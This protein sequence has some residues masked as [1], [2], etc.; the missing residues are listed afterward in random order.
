MKPPH[1][2]GQEG[3]RRSGSADASASERLGVAARPGGEPDV[4]AANVA[5]RA[6]MADLAAW[7]EE[8]ADDRDDDHDDG[9]APRVDDSAPLRSC[10][11]AEELL[12]ALAQVDGAPR[13]ASL[14]PERRGGADLVPPVRRYDAR[15]LAERLLA[16][17]QQHAVLAA[18][19][20]DL[21]AAQ[22]GL[23]SISEDLLARL[24][25]GL[26]APRVGS[27]VASAVGGTERG[28]L[29]L[30]ALQLYVERTKLRRER[31]FVEKVP[32]AQPDPV[33]ARDERLLEVLAVPHA[34]SRPLGE[35]RPRG[36]PRR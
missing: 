9:G 35:R 21:L 34:A 22:A 18:P 31:R 6:P 20:A 24:L 10:R 19:S 33:G 1:E 30:L 12:L 36:R 3:E 2:H 11:E 32:T 4:A 13:R 23:D 8:L 29:A 28:L 16:E 25:S 5:C 26:S 27:D 15:V 17:T 7:L 14:R